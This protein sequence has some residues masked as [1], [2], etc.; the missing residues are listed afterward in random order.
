MQSIADG[1]FG[2]KPPPPI[3]PDNWPD[4]AYALIISTPS[5]IPP[6]IALG[7][8]LRSVDFAVSDFFNA[9]NNDEKRT[10]ETNVRAAVS[11]AAEECMKLSDLLVKSAKK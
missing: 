7:I 9:S 3:Y 2:T 11:D 1:T 8:K 10:R 6:T 5:A 4:V